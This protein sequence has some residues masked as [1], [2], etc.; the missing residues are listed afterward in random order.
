MISLKIFPIKSHINDLTH[1]DIQ[2]V[3]IKNSVKNAIKI[4]I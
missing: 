1:Y 2:R 3:W 4:K